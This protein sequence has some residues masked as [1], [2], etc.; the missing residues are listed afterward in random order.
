ML[1][2]VV[3]PAPFGPSNPTISPAPT[4]TETPLTTRRPR[5]SFARFSVTSNWPFNSVAAVSIS[6]KF[7][8]RGVRVC[9][10]RRRL[11]MHLLIVGVI[12]AFPSINTGIVKRVSGQRV[13]RFAGQRVCI[14]PRHLRL[15]A[16]VEQIGRA[17]V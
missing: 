10:G 11:V 7:Q 9:A 15:R 12:T 5:Y 4:C 6:E 8:R 16:A 14:A 17:H 13:N 1:N 2:V 3:L